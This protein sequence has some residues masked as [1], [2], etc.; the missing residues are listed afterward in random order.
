[1]A[2]TRA[3]RQKFLEAYENYH[4]AIYRHCFFRVFNK[5]RAEEVC[6]EAFM[7]VYDY[8][9]SHEVENIRAFLYRVANNL[10][11]DESRKRKEESLDKLMELYE[12]FGP[13]KDSREESEKHL[14]LKEIFL[15]FTKLTV[16]ERNLLH[17]RYVDDLDPKD[18]APIL[19]ISANNVSVKLNRAMNKLR[20]I[21][22]KKH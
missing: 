18:I 13:S 12:G 14:L 22:T 6:Q 21:V 17:M 5:Q 10:V 15:H 8:M 11:I 7:K 2:M 4:D 3:K 20:K 19:E 16:E 1:M 9:R